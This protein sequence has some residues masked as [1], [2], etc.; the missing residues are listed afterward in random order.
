MHQ[1]PYNCP[2]GIQDAH[3]RPSSHT[4]SVTSAT[5]TPLGASNWFPWPPRWPS[6]LQLGLHTA[7]MA[8]NLPSSWPSK[9]AFGP[10]KSV[11][12]SL[13]I[14]VLAFWAVE[15]LSDCPF[16]AL[17]A[18]L[19]AFLGSTWSSWRPLGLNLEPLGR[20]LG[21][22]WSLLGASWTPL[23]LHISEPKKYQMSKWPPRWPSE[24]RPS[25]LQ[26]PK[27]QNLDF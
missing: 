20:L 19:D 6:E 3:R 7:K 11:V 15:V 22:T 27:S 10:S 5:W 18:F 9:G 23:G 24:L 12:G 1:N 2:N 17:R 26:Q 25:L 8:S 16:V 4:P 14:K 13:K 21:S